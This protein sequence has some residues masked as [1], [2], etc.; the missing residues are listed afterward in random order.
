M[1]DKVHR[2]VRAPNAPFA[3][4]G[5]TAGVDLVERA[6]VV[7]Q[8]LSKST[9]TD[10]GAPNAAASDAEVPLVIRGYLRA[11]SSAAKEAPQKRCTRSRVFL[12]LMALAAPLER[13]I[14]EHLLDVP[15]ASDER[16]LPTRGARHAL[17]HSNYLRATVR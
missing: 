2:A 8:L 1:H 3:G 5:F 4:S 15:A 17:A 7:S 11:P 13:D 6:V 9:V 14:A 16:G 10:R 12:C